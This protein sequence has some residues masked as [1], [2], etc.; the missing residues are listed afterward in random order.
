MKAVLSLAA[1]MLATTVSA[2]SKNDMFT[3]QSLWH[4]PWGK[5]ED[6]RG[7]GNA[8]FTQLIDHQNPSLGTF[9][10]FY[11]YDTTYWKGPGKSFRGYFERATTRDETTAASHWHVMTACGTSG[12]TCFGTR[13]IA[14]LGS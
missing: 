13:A 2:R 8:T 9:E 1:A 7:I 5:C 3:W 10:Q 6:N 12:E 4:L 11:Y 14:Y